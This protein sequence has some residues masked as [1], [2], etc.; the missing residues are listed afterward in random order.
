MPVSTSGGRSAHF[1]FGCGRS[2]AASDYLLLSGLDVQYV[3]F[4][5]SSER[6]VLVVILAV[7]QDAIH[8]VPGLLVVPGRLVASS[9]F[10]SFCFFVFDL[11]VFFDI[12]NEL[13]SVFLNGLKN[14]ATCSYGTPWCESQICKCICSSK[15]L[16]S[17]CSH[18]ICT[19]VPRRCS[20]GI[21]GTSPVR[22]APS[23]LCTVAGSRFH[24]LHPQ[25]DVNSAWRPS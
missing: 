16:V 15:V 25:L 11:D 18:W 6:T 20:C 13:F 9:M 8:R 4:V 5:H 22:K 12:S 1:V 19:V 17:S 7:L 24:H 3:H 21:S 14:S 10:C 23:I 2:L